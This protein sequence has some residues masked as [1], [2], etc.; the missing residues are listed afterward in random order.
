MITTLVGK[1]FLKA[2]NEKYKKNY[3]AKEFFEEV[4]F[5]LFFNHPKYMQWVTN[6]PFVQMKNGQKPHLLSIDERL[7]KLENLYSKVEEEEPDA[8]FAIGFP[9]SESKDFAS[10]SGLVSDIVIEADEEDIYLS[11]IGGGLGVG[12]A[13]GFNLLIN[14]AEI[15]LATFEGWQHYRIYLNDPT[16]EKLRGNQIN[17]WNGQWLTYKLSKNYTEHFNF[18]DLEQEQI[19][20]VDTSLAEVN[21]VNWS[22]LF[23]SLS[24]QF[25]EK[26]LN[27]YIYSLGQTNKTIGFIPIYLKEGRRLKDVFKQLFHTDVP[28]ETKTF[29]SLFG[30]HIKRACE[31]GNI[32]LHA[33]RPDSL[34]KYMEDNKNLSF[35]NEEQI[36]IYQSYKTW[37][38]AMIS[39]NKE[40][41]TDYTSELAKL[42]LRYRSNAKGTTGK[43]LIEKDLFGAKSKRG[44]IEALTEMISV[45]GGSDLDALKNLKDE[46]HLMTN[47]EFGYFSTLLKFDYA[48]EEKQS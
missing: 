30:I 48:F 36:L 1:T 10:T 11:W 12:V 47:E 26:T 18:F 38:I 40:Q 42:I 37:L 2:Y 17:S 39:K 31:L 34:K 28:F 4:Y 43:N 21:T 9:A 23:F 25:P 7:E 45:L 24:N 8:S 5:E 46:V 15:T 19:F 14:D 3:S 16:L 44:F 41:I 29:Q 35:K 27:A 20:K 22:N 32:G 13:G 33:L 6:S